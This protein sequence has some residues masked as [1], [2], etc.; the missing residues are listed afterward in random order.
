MVQDWSNPMTA[1]KW[2]QSGKNT[3]PLREEQLDILVT[4]LA[5]SYQPNKWILDLG[6]GSGQIEKTIFERIPLAKIVGIDNSDAM[7]E[8]ARQRLS[9][10]K[11]EFVSIKWDLANIDSLK[12]P[13]HQYGHVLAIQSLH[14]LSKTEMQAAYSRI[15]EI[16]MPGGLFL[17]L[18]RIRIETTNLWSLFHTIWHRQDSLY[19]SVVANHEGTTFKEHE[20]IV[21]DRG[22]FPVLLDEHLNWLR[23]TGFEAACLHLH[24]NR[25]LIAGIK[26]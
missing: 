25:A 26:C 8:L 3:N 21:R 19:G 17:L 22:D 11:N 1:M 16:L 5:N 23:E 20:R 10:Y 24:G 15:H 18:D 6:Y 7:M 14:H 13:P 4:L 2:D 12:L 9:Q